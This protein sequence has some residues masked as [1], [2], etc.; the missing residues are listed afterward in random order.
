MASSHKTIKRHGQRRG[1]DLVAAAQKSYGAK[2]R[3]SLEKRSIQPQERTPSRGHASDHIRQLHPK[4]KVTHNHLLP[5]IDM[6]KIAK[7][8]ATGRCCQVEVV[9]D[10]DK[11]GTTADPH[12]IYEDAIPNE[13]RQTAQDYRDYI[14]SKEKLTRILRSMT[15]KELDEKVEQL[16]TLQ[17][18]TRDAA[19]DLLP[20]P[21]SA[22]ETNAFDLANPIVDTSCS[23]QLWRNIVFLITTKTIGSKSLDEDN[24]IQPFAT[25]R[26]R[27]NKSISDFAQRLKAAVDTYIVLKLTAPTDKNQA[28]R[29]V[30]GLDPARYSTMQM[31]F[32]NELNN[33]RD[34]YP[35]DL[36]S[37]VCKANRWLVPSAR[38]PQDVAQ[39]SVL[40]V[41]ARG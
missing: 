24:A 34:I 11:V 12:G 13:I 19:F 30:Q 29:F 7:I 14:K 3:Q 6:S 28:M 18:A 15:S 4:C 33:G 39:H 23:L 9:I 41:Q 22:A 1:K 35:T 27:T 36:T 10:N 37:A 32:M 5:K 31:H 40:G 2:K 16:F 26:Q 25:L 20:N 8:L 38:G 21:P 17:L